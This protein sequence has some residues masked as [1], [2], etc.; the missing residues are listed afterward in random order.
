MAAEAERPPKRE[1]P[2]YDGRSGGGQPTR[3]GDVALWVPRVA[4][5]PLYL[6]SEYVVRRPLGFV[7]TA[8]EK[9]QVPAAIYDFLAFGPNHSAGFVPLAFVDFGFD[10][11]VGLYLFWD[12][13]GFEGHDLRARGSTWG[14]DWLSGTL[15]ERF[16]FG[17]AAQL[18]LTGT[19]TRRPDYTFYGVGSSSLEDDRSRY[20]AST[21][22]ARAEF[23]VRLPASSSLETALG[24]RSA[25]FRPGDY[26]EDPSLPEQ[27]A[28]GVYEAPAGYPRGYS[29]LVGRTRLKLDSRAR[30][31]VGRGSGV[32]L[33][34]DAEQGTSSWASPP[35]GWVRYGAAV[36]GVFDLSD[37][38]RLL[39][40]SVATRFAE[41]LGSQPVP[42]TELVSLG[43]NDL[44]PGFRPG[45]LLGRSAAV[46]TLRYAWPIWIW[47]HGTM[48]AAV[49]NV[50]DTQLKGLEPG[51]LRFS[52]ALGIESHGST[53]SVLQVLIGF[54]TETFESGGAMES[55]RLALGARSGF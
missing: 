4:L 48:Q 16:Q 12:D 29:A 25:R 37:N 18:T 13:V 40:L 20:G 19:A 41:P 53:D 22:D 34:L 46:G 1:L 5:F 43:G 9:A 47:L 44:L 55:I 11:S 21:V 51:L 3:P 35:T 28:D 33:D 26:G 23:A 14:K 30:D 39:S 10:P 42:F 36:G 45:R 31:L 8:A 32:R 6:T 49:G 50:F 27:V 52:G 2:D 7:I 24:Y 54:G 15:T 17:P 38:G